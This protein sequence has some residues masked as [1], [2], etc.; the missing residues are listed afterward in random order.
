MSSFFSSTAFSWI[1]LCLAGLCESGWSA[2][3]SRGLGLPRVWNTVVFVVFLSA[4]MGG[5]AL[6]LRRIPVGVGYAVW[7]GIGAV[8][9]AVFAVIRGVEP[10]SVVQI[11]CLALIVCGIVGLGIVR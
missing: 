5:L 7:T 2:A 6:G 1:A 8:S 10:L 9:T 4:S 11:V 3:L